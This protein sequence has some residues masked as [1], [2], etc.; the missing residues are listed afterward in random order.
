MESHPYIKT[1]IKRHNLKRLYLYFH[2]KD[3]VHCVKENNTSNESF[4]GFELSTD[5]E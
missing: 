3:F 4:Q 5:S 2:I 1:M